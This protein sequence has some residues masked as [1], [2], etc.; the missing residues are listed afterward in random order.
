MLSKPVFSTKFHIVNTVTQQLEL[1]RGHFPLYIFTPINSYHEKHC[2][3]HTLEESLTTKE[4]G[5]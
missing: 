1:N 3:F 2:P 4:Q 5:V